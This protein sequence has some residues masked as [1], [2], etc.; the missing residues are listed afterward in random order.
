M[1]LQDDL[2]GIGSNVKIV[3]EDNVGIIK[4]IVNDSIVVDNYYEND[5][6]LVGP[7]QK[8]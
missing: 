4:D 5:N 3:G 8:M 1:I 7:H 6:Y 2:S